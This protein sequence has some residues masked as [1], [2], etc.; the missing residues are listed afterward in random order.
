MP[1]KK[2]AAVGSTIFVTAFL[3]LVIDIAGLMKA[4]TSLTI[5]G[6][7][8]EIEIKIATYICAKSAWPGAVWIRSTWGGTKFSLKKTVTWLAILL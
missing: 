8:H 2:S 1:A 5:M 4:K 6:T 7:A 3:L